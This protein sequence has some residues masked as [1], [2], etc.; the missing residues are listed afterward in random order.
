MHRRLWL[1][2]LLLANLGCVANGQERANATSTLLGP[3]AGWDGCRLELHDVH[4]LW[5]GVAVYVDGRGSCYVERVDQ[6]RGAKRFWRAIPQDDARA[7]FRLA[8]EDDVAGLEIPERPG[9]PDEA[10]PAIHVIGPESRRAVS[11]WENDA[12]ERFDRLRQALAALTTEVGEPTWTGAYDPAWH[13]LEGAEVTVLLYSGRP[14]PSWN[15]RQG[16]L[17]PVLTRLKELDDAAPVR[18]PALGF[19]G[20]RLHLRTGEPA[21]NV[22]VYQGTILLQQRNGSSVTLADERGLE[23]WLRDQAAARGIEIPE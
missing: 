6:S 3:E 2:L 22:E 9:V 1:G 17:E 13:P 21:L 19:R 10:R 8:S 11:K 15:V 18:R 14:D 5:G 4:G 12:V 20:F 16:D 23:D 7:L